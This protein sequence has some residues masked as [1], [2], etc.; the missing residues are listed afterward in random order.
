L[1]KLLGLSAGEIK[2]LEKERVVGYWDYRVGQRPPVYYD[3]Q[4]DPI[5]N[6]E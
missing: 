4:K 5:F 1:K 3:I 2:E 6:Y